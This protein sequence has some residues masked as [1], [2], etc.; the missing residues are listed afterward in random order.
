M[1]KRKSQAG[2]ENRR[3]HTGTRAARQDG[4]PAAQGR[5]AALVCPWI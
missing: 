3:L 4:Q 1:F 2:P 5:S